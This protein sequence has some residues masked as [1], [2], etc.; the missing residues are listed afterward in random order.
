MTNIVLQDEPVSKRSCKGYTKKLAFLETTG[1]DYLKH[2]PSAI[3]F[4]NN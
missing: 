2:G 1:A 4:K 3:E